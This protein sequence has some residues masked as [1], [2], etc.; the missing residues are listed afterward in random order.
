MLCAKTK[1]FQD[2]CNCAGRMF[3]ERLNERHLYLLVHMDD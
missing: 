1:E 3:R 2:L